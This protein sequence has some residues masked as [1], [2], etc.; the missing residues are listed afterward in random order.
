MG[1]SQSKESDDKSNQQEVVCEDCRKETQQ[2]L[3]ESDTNA[4]VGGKCHAIY[5]QVDQCMRKHNHQVTKCNDEWKAFRDCR[6][7]EKKP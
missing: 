6:Q 3:P 7:Q 1:T 4:S 2:P 5:I